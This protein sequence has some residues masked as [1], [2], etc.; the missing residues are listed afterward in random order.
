M[1]PPLRLTREFL[2]AIKLADA[3]AYRLAAE[4]G[5]APAM[6]SRMMRGADIVPPGTP[7]HQKLLQLG[8]LLRVPARAC[9]EPAHPLK[10]AGA[11]GDGPGASSEAFGRVTRPQAG[12]VASKRPRDAQGAERKSRETA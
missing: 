4:V 11:A 12:R 9:F 10:P 3:P 6:L 1:T 5:M 8:R 7:K 2:A